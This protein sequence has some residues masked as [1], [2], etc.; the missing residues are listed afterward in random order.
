MN[1]QTATR[2]GL[3]RDSRII[4]RDG[5]TLAVT[6][7]RGPTVRH[8][9][10]LLHGLCQNRHTWNPQP[11]HIIKLCGADTQVIAYD[12]RG[13]GDSDP[14]PVTT[15]SVDQLAD[16]LDDIL[17]TLNI[18]G[19]VTLVGHSL[20]GMVALAYLG[21]PEH[22]HTGDVHG[23]VL[24]ASAAGGLTESGLG[25]LLALRIITPL[26]NAIAHS[27]ITAT[28]ALSA[29]LRTA[30]DHLRTRGGL[31]QQ[32][33]MGAAASALATTPLRTA[34]GYLPS[35]RD[36]DQRAALSH[37][38]AATM[39][40]SGGLDVLTPTTHAEQMAAQ[41]PG[42]THQHFPRAGHMLPQLETAAV[43]QAIVTT[44]TEASRPHPAGVAS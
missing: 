31:Q 16:D 17:T 7:W 33:L 10:I 13:H 6:R 11:D 23:L 2:T 29:F 41:I 8:T 40:L 15:Y 12:H 14:A 44:I 35:L 4:T 18:T 38:A 9:V 3:R 21:R 24:C 42:A 20:G 5:T 32:T 22:R 39:I 19:P 43:C 27:P 34:L 26:A 37:I 25:R 1:S 30:A 28:R 36:F